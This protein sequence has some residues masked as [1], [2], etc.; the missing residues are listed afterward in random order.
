MM[1]MVNF[2]YLDRFD[3]N[4]LI[5]NRKDPGQKCYIKDLDNWVDIADCLS[6]SWD[7]VIR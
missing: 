6:G 7:D 4:E 1:V 3:N 5:G 2:I